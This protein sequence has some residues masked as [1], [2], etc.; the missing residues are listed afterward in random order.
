MVYRSPEAKFEA[1]KTLM[2]DLTEQI[3]IN[4]AH[5][6]Y[7]EILEVGDYNFPD[8]T[9]EQGKLPPPQSNNNK[10]GAQANILVEYLRETL[11]FQAILEPTRN[12]NTLDL[13]LINNPEMIK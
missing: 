2:R 6:G 1:F 3:I 12:F 4:Q 8:I 7:P 11:S 9:W 10:E 13:I 5:G